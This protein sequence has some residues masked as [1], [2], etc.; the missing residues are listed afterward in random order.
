MI[1]SIAELSLAQSEKDHVTEEKAVLLCMRSDDSP[2]DTERRRLHLLI[3][4]LKTLR[5]CSRV[6]VCE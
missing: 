1:L 4:V 5:I 6:S 2:T 3:Y